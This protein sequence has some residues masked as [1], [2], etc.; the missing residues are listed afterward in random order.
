MIKGTTEA[1]AKKTRGR[2]TRMKPDQ[3]APSSQS[4]MMQQ[5]RS[6][7]RPTSRRMSVSSTSGVPESFP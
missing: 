3:S 1:G 4:G 7:D 2:L 5:T 6:I